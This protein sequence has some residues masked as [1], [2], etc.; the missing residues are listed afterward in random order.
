M[1]LYFLHDITCSDLQGLYSVFTVPY[2][3]QAVE[4][5]TVLHIRRIAGMMTCSNNYTYNI[6]YVHKI[7]IGMLCVLE[8]CL[9]PSFPCEGTGQQQSFGFGCSRW[10][11]CQCRPVKFINH[12][13][14]QWLSTKRQTFKLGAK[15]T[16][17]YVKIF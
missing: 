1:F 14:N 9:K 4:I 5:T 17:N 7:C 3:E 12:T 13:L 16:S 6:S 10:S 11:L 8:A 2:T 15:M